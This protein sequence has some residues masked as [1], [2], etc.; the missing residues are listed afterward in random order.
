MVIVKSCLPKAACVSGATCCEGDNCNGDGNRDR[1]SD[2]T[3]AG[4][5]LDLKA[6]T[7]CKEGFSPI[8]TR[9]EDCENAAKALGFTGNAVSKVAHDGKWGTSKPQGCFQSVGVRNPN[10]R[11]HF[12]RG[13]GGTSTNDKILC[14]KEIAA[15]RSTNGGCASL[16]RGYKCEGKRIKY[17]FVDN[18]AQC[19][20]WCNDVGG[21]KCCQFDGKDYCE[22]IDGSKI[23]GNFAPRSSASVCK[24]IKCYV[25]EPKGTGAGNL[26]S[27]ELYHD[28]CLRLEYDDGNVQ[29]SCFSSTYLSSYNITRDE[30]KRIQGTM[31]CSCSTDGCNAG[32]FK[33]ASSKNMAKGFQMVTPILLV[34][35]ISLVMKNLLI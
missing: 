8:I 34:V 4:N 9:W 7:R 23:E 30:C 14:W 16:Q 6:G 17:G 35:I 2:V 24:T 19:Q 22:A 29:R 15:T 5:T 26:T 32:Y 33:S 31:T 28:T 21:T 3:Y 25:L 11:F 20:A 18:E 1:S 12:N 13:D 27:C 10:G